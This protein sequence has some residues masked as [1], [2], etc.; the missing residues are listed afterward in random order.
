VRSTMMDVPLTVTAIMRHGTTAYAN[1]E[2]VTLTA[3]GVR[4]QSCE[5]LA[6]TLTSESRP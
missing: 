6:W 5:A 3:T 2:V 4:R 1:S